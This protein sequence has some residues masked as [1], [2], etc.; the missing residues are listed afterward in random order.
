V[1]TL[2]TPAD[3]T[4]YLIWDDRLGT[5]VPALIDDCSRGGIIIHM[6]KN[7]LQHAHLHT[8]QRLHRQKDQVKQRGRSTLEN[9]NILVVV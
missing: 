7:Q 5:I 8:K 9:L 6:L 3:F 4:S 1:R 2:S